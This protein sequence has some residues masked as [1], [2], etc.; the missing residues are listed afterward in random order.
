MCCRLAAARSKD[1]RERKRHAAAAQAWKARYEKR[2]RDAFE[3]HGRVVCCSKAE[4]SAD[5]RRQSRVVV[6]MRIA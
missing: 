5:I 3:R 1:S 4:E 2:E 6:L